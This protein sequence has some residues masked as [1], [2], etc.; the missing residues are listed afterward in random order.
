MT[1]IATRAELGVELSSHRYGDYVEAVPSN[2]H[3]AA[4]GL[5][6]GDII[7][8][9]GK[10]GELQ[11]PVKYYEGYSRVLLVI[12]NDNVVSEACPLSLLIMRGEEKG[13]VRPRINSFNS[14]ESGG[15]SKSSPDEISSDTSL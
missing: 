7:T 14:T 9:A 8:K 11:F 15:S 3:G 1:L 4:I 5:E 13:T 10:V 2:S 12:G 6:V